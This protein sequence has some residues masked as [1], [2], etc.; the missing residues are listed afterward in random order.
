[1]TALTIVALVV[2]TVLVAWL[3]SG[4][5]HRTLRRHSILA[6]PEK[7]SS[8]IL[9]TPQGG[10]I[11]VIGATT[12]GWIAIG[13]IG[14]GNW[15]SL[16]VVLAATLALAIV[17]WFDDVGQLPVMPRIT[18]Q[19][20]T[21]TTVMLLA[22]MEPLTDGLLPIPLDRILCGLLSVSYTHLTLPTS[23]LV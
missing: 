21:V 1:M 13:A 5:A 22:P 15:P 9:P 12:L 19:V 17:S 3:T 10:G 23:D 11:A 16:G 7:R 20:A 18:S 14:I 4:M 8:H 2:M 6:Q